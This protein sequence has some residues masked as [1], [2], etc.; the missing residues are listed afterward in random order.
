MQLS[1][2]ERLWQSLEALRILATSSE[3][4]CLAKLGNVVERQKGHSLDCGLSVVVS[5]INLQQVEV[6]GT[7]DWA[8]RLPPLWVRAY[9]TALCGGTVGRGGRTA[10]AAVLSLTLLKAG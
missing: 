8:L 10:A 4:L 6:V 9:V 3:L 5:S 7:C 1:I 2:T